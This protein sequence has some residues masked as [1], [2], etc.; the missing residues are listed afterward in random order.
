MTESGF[1]RILLVTVLSFT[2]LG[3][4]FALHNWQAS[5]QK[6]ADAVERH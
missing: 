2:L 3:W 5:P 4:G 1:F 6:V